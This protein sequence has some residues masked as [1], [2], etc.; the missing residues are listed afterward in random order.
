[1]KLLK[2]SLLSACIVSL[3]FLVGCS[4][5]K[6]A[7]EA[8]TKTDA[9]QT[10][11]KAT[12]SVKTDEPVNPENKIVTKE[13]FEKTFFSQCKQGAIGLSEDISTKLCQ[14]TFDKL[15]TEYTIETLIDMDIKKIDIPQN[16]QVFTTES[17][18]ACL[19]SITE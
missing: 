7:D 9:T 8:T 12:D 3:A 18:Q 11:D 13:E 16:F 15:V 6:A 19:K 14:C 4:E 17:A 1:M 10:A 2:T 5:E